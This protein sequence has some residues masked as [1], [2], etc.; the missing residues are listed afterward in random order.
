[1]TGIDGR[2]ELVIEGSLDGIEWQEYE[3]FY[4]PGK[5]DER[6]KF[7]L[8]HQPRID[9]QMCSAALGD[10][11]NS[12]IWLTNM[13]DKIFKNSQSV[14]SIFKE[15]P[16]PSGPNYLR[17]QKYK[18]WFTSRSE[19]QTKG[20]WWKRKFDSVY[21]EPIHRNERKLKEYL[22]SNG[23]EN[24]DFVYP[25]H[26]LQEIPILEIIIGFFLIVIFTNLLNLDT[27]ISEKN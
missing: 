7:S 6:P 11:I 13:I 15:N 20:W 2:P 5:M 4:K 14:L 26:I 21:M 16:F 24:I 3:F 23:F 10:D 19:A 8:T 9:W 1:M 12:E 27:K 17:I 18:Y 25:L 22:K